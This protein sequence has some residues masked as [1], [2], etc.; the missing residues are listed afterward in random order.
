MNWPKITIVT[1]T[2]NSEKYLEETILTVIEQD[3]PNLEY[4]IIDGCSTDG[5]IDIIKKYEKNLAYWESSPDKTMYEA[6]VK[7]FN[8]ATGE[9]LGWLN[10]DDIYEAGA[11]E[12]VGK[13]FLDNPEH[14]VIYFE[15][16]VEKEGWRVPNR[17]QPDI[18]LADMLDCHIVYQDGVFF[19]R[20]AYQ[21][22]GGINPSLRY[23]GDYDLWLRLSQKFK[24]HKCYGHVSCF[25]IRPDQLS[26]SDWSRYM[27]EVSQCRDAFLLFLS[28]Y[29]IKSAYLIK[30]VRDIYNRIARRLRRRFW[31]IEKE[32]LQWPPVIKR[33]DYSLRDCICPV[34]GN[35]PQRL[36]FSTPDTRFGDKR[37][38]RIYECK[39]CISAFTFPKPDNA[40]LQELYERN[41]SGNI[42]GIGA[43]PEGCYSLYKG[44]SLYSFK[45]VDVLK[46]LFP[47]FHK[48]LGM[49]YDDIVPIQ[50]NLDAAIL[51]IGCF[52]GRILEYLRYKGYRNTYG[53]ELNK[54]ASEAAR[55]KGFIIN[56]EDVTVSDW[57][58]KP[59]DAIIL[60]QVLEHVSDPAGFMR[61]VARL[62]KSEGR[63][64]LSL[65]NYDS[66]FIDF[67]G[68][69]WAH[70][71]IPYHFFIPSRKTIKKIAEKSGFKVKWFKTSTPVHYAY[72]SEA[73]SRVG[74]G[75][76]VSHNFDANK[77]DFQEDWKKAMGV[78]VLSW[79]FI[80]PFCRGDCL[81]VK[82]VKK[83]AGNDKQKK[84][85]S[86]VG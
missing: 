13:Y 60:N 42:Q 83:K 48:L 84:Q 33:S 55:A 46:K 30:C 43:A 39:T 27:S 81:Y 62:L 2:K 57:P 29:K 75:G 78:T 85:K 72:M 8:R 67:Y 28:P 40:T 14:H 21:S 47:F 77:P 59:V 51:D 68:P 35:F 15:D 11:L 26:V 16:T 31:P 1:P 32:D 49:L 3:Y 23:A 4:I 20:S 45:I 10:S 71:H 65:P 9:I 41:Y 74:L 37:V 12:R 69:A 79:L 80:D 61:S 64:Y 18:G 34:C 5:T 63:V 22:V 36:L 52:E 24:L 19:R 73:L 56:S 86:R 50:E 76:Y 44:R 70:W 53:V 6:V 25:R 38:W 7:G 58:G 17:A 82:L 66:A 54:K